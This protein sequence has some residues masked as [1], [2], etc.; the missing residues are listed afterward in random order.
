MVCV[1]MNRTIKGTPLHQRAASADL[2]PEE[3]LEIGIQA[4]SSGEVTKSTYHLS[5]AA[6]SG[7]PTGMLLY[8]LAC[9]H[10]WGMRANQEESHACEGF[11]ALG[12]KL[13]P[14]HIYAHVETFRTVFTP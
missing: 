10:G 13:R 11:K 7:L 12:N 8:A 14:M 4:H 6:I 2:T 3:H 9:R 1:Q 5:L